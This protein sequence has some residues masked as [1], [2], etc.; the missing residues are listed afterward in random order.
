MIRHH[1]LLELYLAETLG[2]DVDDVHDEADRLEHALSE[3]LEARIDQRARLPDARPARRPDPGREPRLAEDASGSGEP[4]AGRPKNTALS[5]ASSSLRTE[6]L[7]ASRSQP[8]SSS[9]RTSSSSVAVRRLERVLQLVALEDV[10]VARAAR[11]SR[12]AAG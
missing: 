12:G 11:R 5:G 7:H 3:E 4:L 10:V 2:L 1:R 9:T 8:S 6:R